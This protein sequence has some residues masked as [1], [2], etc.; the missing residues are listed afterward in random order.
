MPLR[1]PISGQNDA[2]P[3]PSGGPAPGLRLRLA[4]AGLC[5]VHGVGAAAGRRGLIDLG[6]ALTGDELAVLRDLRGAHG[7]AVLGEVAVVLVLERA[8]GRGGHRR[9]G[10]GEEEASDAGRDE[11]LL[12]WDSWVVEGR[13][14]F[15]LSVR[16]AA[17]ARCAPFV[18][19]AGTGY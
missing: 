4:A 15:D 19:Y 6:V 18:P 13:A 7:E 10:T 5:A 3:R 9:T 2:G 1:P 14:S 17:G 11:K 12:H 8:V 16:S